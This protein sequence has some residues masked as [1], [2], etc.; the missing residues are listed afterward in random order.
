MTPAERA[1]IEALAQQAAAEQRAAAV[2][3][4]IRAEML[5]PLEQP[6][7]G[8]CAPCALPSTLTWQVAFEVGT[9]F[10]VRTVSVCTEC[11]TEDWQ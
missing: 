2:V 10:T 4:P 9:D 3:L 11:G 8:W 7:R 6:D 1:E 5:T